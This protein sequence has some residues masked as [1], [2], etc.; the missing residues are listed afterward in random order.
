MKKCLPIVVVL[1]V[2]AV[3][4]AGL[5]HSVVPNAGGSASPAGYNTYDL[6]V[7]TDGASDWSNSL[8]DGRLTAGTFYQ[9][10]LGG[11]LGSP[12]FWS[13]APYLE[14]DTQVFAPD[15]V[16]PTISSG[17]ATGVYYGD[18]PHD[19]TTEFIG[20]WGDSVTTSVG[21][22][23]IA[24]LTVSTDAQGIVLAYLGPQNVSGSFVETDAGNV[25]PFELDITD[26]VVTLVPEPATMVLLGLGGIGALLR[27]RR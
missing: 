13:L 17:P 2:A 18:P 12:G 3:A 22:Y 20:S 9:G 10:A 16:Q 26:G 5:V 14:W 1:A 8:I 15:M 27:K 4:N 11:F 7:T 21:S 6:V 19:T 24:R 23:V 25:I